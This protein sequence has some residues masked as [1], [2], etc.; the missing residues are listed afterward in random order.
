MPRSPRAARAAPKLGAEQHAAIRLGA[1]LRELALRRPR[2]S[3][4]VPRSLRAA[5]RVDRAA[6]GRRA[7]ARKEEDSFPWST[8]RWQRRGL[9]QR[10]YVRRRVHGRRSPDVA[11]RMA[12]AQARASCDL[13][14]A[15]ALEARRD[16]HEVGK[17]DPRWPARCSRSILST[18]PTSPK[19]SK[20][21]RSV[22]ESDPPADG[23]PKASLESGRTTRS[24]RRR[25]SRAWPKATTSRFVAYF[26]ATPIGERLERL[27]EPRCASHRMATTLGF[28]PATALHRTTPQGWS[29]SRVILL[30]VG[31]EGDLEIPGEPYGS[32]VAV[33]QG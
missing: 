29:Q 17:G 1:A 23:Y 10:P 26:H 25:H 2:Q 28:G 6:A 13:V 3:H 22:L 18:S 12:A 16:I 4:L 33:A 9:R 27:R 14:S 11:R 15:A 5:R 24:S 32:V 31:T 8:N 30:T 20:A 21:T 19:P 7:P